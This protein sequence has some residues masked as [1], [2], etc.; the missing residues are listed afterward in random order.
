M[1]AEAH[2]D[3]EELKAL[4]HELQDIKD[5]MMPVKR[6]RDCL[7]KTAQRVV[8]EADVTCQRRLLGPKKSW[9]GRKK[10]AR[11]HCSNTRS[12]TVQP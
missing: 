11:P 1:E 6:E 9:L 4:K 8:L 5:K 10:K 12:S 2:R 3:R 7:F